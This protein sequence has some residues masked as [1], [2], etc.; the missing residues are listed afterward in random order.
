MKRF[1]VIEEKSPL[2]LENRIN[3][4]AKDHWEVVSHSAVQVA[5]PF[6]THDIIY[7]A[8]LAQKYVE[9]MSNRDDLY[10]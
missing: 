3:E 4:L 1:K 9:P 2:H 10:D 8:I 5:G 7:T 6:N